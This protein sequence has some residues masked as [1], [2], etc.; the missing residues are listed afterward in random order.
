MVYARA[1]YTGTSTPRFGYRTLQSTGTLRSR[2]SLQ[3]TGTLHGL[4]FSELDYSTEE[5]DEENAAEYGQENADE[6]GEAE[7]GLDYS[8]GEEDSDEQRGPVAAFRY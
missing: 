8:S 4:R 6:Y 1:G 7:Y 3:S 2:G 5:S